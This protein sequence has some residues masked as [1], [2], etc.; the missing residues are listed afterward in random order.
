ILKEIKTL[1]AEPVSDEELNAVK[2][3]LIAANVMN[4]EEN[5]KLNL[6]MVLD[7][8]YGLGYKNFESYS[9]RINDV[10]AG[11]IKRVANQYLNPDSCLIVTIYGTKEGNK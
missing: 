5:A 9:S 10:T 3:H 4:L 6:E 1:K 11:Q 8:L 2:R 7:E